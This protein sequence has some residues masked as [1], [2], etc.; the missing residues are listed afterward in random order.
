M[1]HL[2]LVLLLAVVGPTAA[3]AARVQVLAPA[4]GEAYAAASRELVTRLARAGIAAEPVAL[5]GWRPEPDVALVVALGS[6][7]AHAALHAEP[8]RPVLAALLPR[9]AWERALDGA[10]AGPATALWLDQPAERELRLIGQVVPSARRVGVLLGPATLARRPALE[11]AAAAAGVALRVRT[12]DVD[13]DPKRA[14][15]ALVDEVD[16]ILALP[17][18]AVWNRI[19]VEPL[20]LATFRAGVPVVGI[21]PTYVRA[22]AIAAVHSTPAQ[23]AAELAALI[24]RLDL[25][26]DPL[27]LPAPRPPRE[28]EVATNPEVARALG[29]PPSDPDALAERL[30]AMEGRP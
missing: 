14:L 12:I 27:V 10:P 28:F 20:L 2:L 4:E 21:S 5:D 16:A 26:G 25:G 24:A 7:A 17:D 11:R 29:L 23:V 13:S 3:G 19:T 9:E 1:R 30:R 18:P 15:G 8:R 6:R 22:G